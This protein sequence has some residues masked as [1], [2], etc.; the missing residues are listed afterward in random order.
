M[1]LERQIDRLKKLIL[2][3]GARVEQAVVDAIRAV[4]HRDLDLARKVM[5][6]DRE[7]DLAEL[8]VEEEC[9][10]TLA[11]YQPVAQDMRYVVAVLKINAELE[12]IGDL[13]SGIAELSETLS[14]RAALDHWP[15]DLHEMTRIVRSMVSGSLDA[16]VNID[17][18]LAH[19]VR[20][21]DEQVDR[22][23]ADMYD[24]VEQAIRADPEL[25]RTYMHLMGVSRQL[26]RIADHAVNIAEDVIYMAEGKILRHKKPVPRSPQENTA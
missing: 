13:A 12:R 1:H 4:E 2:S 21:R 5:A 26:E 24:R 14:K 19:D 3:L 10:H 25:V 18:K 7:I 22:I 8:D 15:F 17:V 11:L 9:L 23:H 6:G 20:M 16:L